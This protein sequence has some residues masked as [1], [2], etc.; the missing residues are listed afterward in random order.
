MAEH[1]GTPGSDGVTRRDFV[2]GTLAGATALGALPMLQACTGGQ[3]AVSA[4]DYPPLR[5]GMRGSHPGSSG[6]SRQRSSSKQPCTQ[7][8]QST[9][10]TANGERME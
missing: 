8:T 3:P 9:Q 10:R 1:D 5:T 2:Q 7:R 4:A 6:S